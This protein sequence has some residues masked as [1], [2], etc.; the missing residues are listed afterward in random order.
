MSADELIRRAEELEREVAS[1]Q[2]RLDRSLGE[3]QR[4]E[5][6]I[7]RLQKLVEE[8][9]RKRKRNAAPFSR[10]NPKLNPKTAGRKSGDQYGQQA[11]RPTPLQV[12]EQIAVPLPP[13]CPH[14]ESRVIRETTKAQ[15]QEDIVRVTLVR[16][17][18]VEVGVC[19]GC[20]GR[21]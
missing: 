19:A 12:N 17:Y 20:G 4:L 5:Q 21:V 2:R 8:A 16:R 10:G 18:D 13:C 15:Y 6:E 3:N 11:T 14:C 7:A 9:L 1:L